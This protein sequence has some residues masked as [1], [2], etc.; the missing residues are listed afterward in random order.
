LGDDFSILETLAFAIVAVVLFL[1]LRSVL[2]KRTGSERPRAFQPFQPTGPAT[3]NRQTGEVVSLPPRPGLFRPEAGSIDP[4]AQP[5]ATGIERIKSVDP[6][7]DE[8]AFLGGA[9]I[10][11]EMIVGSYAQGDTATLKPLLAP[12]VYENFAAAIRNRD[13][14]GERLETRIEAVRK[15]ELIEAS[16]NGRTALVTVKFTTE[17]VNVT[18]DK[19]GQVLDGAPD[20]PHEV[21]D[22]WVF[23]RD[24][25]ATDPNWQLVAT[26]TPS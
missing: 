9:R 12:P 1:R 24:A 10:A 16:L 3:Q 13:E 8:E 5:L 6:Q 21:V 22:I 20:E 17:Q 23:A 18:R 26:R 15:V 4:S 19:D 7:F 2:G 25:R 14:A 11:F